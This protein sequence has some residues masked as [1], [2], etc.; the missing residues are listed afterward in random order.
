M[1]EDVKEVDDYNNDVDID[2][3]SCESIEEETLVNSKQETSKQEI[4][5]DTEIKNKENSADNDVANKDL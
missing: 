1:T 5:E 3:I 4:G 2:N